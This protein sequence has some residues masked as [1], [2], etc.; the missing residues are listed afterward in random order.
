MNGTALGASATGRPV[1]E[2]VLFDAA[3]TLFDLATPLP[4]VLGEAVAHFGGTCRPERLKRALDH[5]GSTTGWPD[6]QPD[7]TSRA[8]A[9]THFA[10]QIIGTAD[11]GM[12]EVMRRRAAERA[13]TAVLAP[14]NYRVFDEVTGLLADLVAARVPIGIV[15]NFD[16]LLVDIL[17]TTGL[18]QVFTTVVTSYRFGVCKPDPRIFHEA[19]GAIRTSP[20][21]TCYVGDSVYSDMGGARNAGLYGVLV[22]REGLHG[23]YSGHRIGSLAEVRGLLPL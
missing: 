8:R 13:V 19:V 6:D 21:S 7:H 15:S 17:R 1:I 22:D 5:V 4:Q 16:D 9:W 2:G 11:P 23:D 3:G 20:A 10:E 18:E 12:A 14:G